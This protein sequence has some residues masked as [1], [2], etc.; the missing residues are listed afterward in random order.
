LIF[1]QKYQICLLGG[2]HP[3]GIELG[4]KARSRDIL[5]WGVYGPPE[6]PD[7]MPQ[8]SRFKFKLPILQAKALPSWGLN[9]V[10]FKDSMLARA[11]KAAEVAK[12]CQNQTL[13]VFFGFVVLLALFEKM[14]SLKR[15]SLLTTHRQELSV[16]DTED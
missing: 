11:A 16:S 9:S 14:I 12:A 8:A 1:E 15:I 6:S 5:H 13:T 10:K 2:Q 4:G 3:T 7:S